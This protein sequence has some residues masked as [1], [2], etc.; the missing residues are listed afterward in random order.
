MYNTGMFR[1]CIRAILAVSLCGCAV[2]TEYNPVQAVHKQTFVL[3]ESSLKAAAIG[4]TQEEVHRLVGDAIIIGYSYQ[5]TASK[6]I[7]LA[8]PYKTNALKTKHG[9]CTVEYYVTAVHQPDG[10]VSDDE[11]MPLLFCNG[12]LKAKGWDKVK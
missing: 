7:T 1:A 9:D 11:L 8:N 6:P 10:V 2:T 4:M 5:D 12:T 3:N